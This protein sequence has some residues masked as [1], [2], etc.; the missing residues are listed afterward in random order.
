MDSSS[1]Q[2]VKLAKVSTV[3]LGQL[4]SRVFR[5]GDIEKVTGKDGRRG[6]GMTKDGDGFF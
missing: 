3:V 6:N 1:K 2:P 5:L 4:R